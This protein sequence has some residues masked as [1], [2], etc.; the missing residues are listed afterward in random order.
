MFDEA[1]LPDG[2]FLDEVPSDSGDECHRN[3][4]GISD[5]RSKKFFKEKQR[6][7]P[8]F[9][10]CDRNEAHPLTEEDIQRELEKYKQSL[11]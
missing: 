3:I 7:S 1:I 9:Q 6:E 2:Y 11:R 10:I 5:N 8:F 4:E